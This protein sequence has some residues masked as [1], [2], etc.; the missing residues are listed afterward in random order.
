M[1]KSLG[2][3]M[4]VL[5]LG[6]AACPV[7][8][9]EGQGDAAS[10]RVRKVDLASAADS[11]RVRS[12]QSSDADYSSR[13]RKADSVNAAQEDAR[14]RVAQADPTD[15]VQEG[16]R[17]RSAQ[18]A[19]GESV[20]SNEGN[21]ATAAGGEENT[22]TAGTETPLLSAPAAPEKIKT[23]KYPNSKLPVSTS[24]PIGSVYYDYVDKLEGMGY[25]KSM[26]I[27]TRPYSRMDM[28]RWTLEARDALDKNPNATDFVFTMVLRLEKALAPEIA[29]IEAFNNDEKPKTRFKVQ[30]TRVELAGTDLHSKNGYEYRNLKNTRWQ[31]FSQNNKGHRYQDGFNANASIYMDGNLGRDLALSVTARA[32]WDKENHLTG[33]FDEAYLA[34][35]LGIWNI[36]IGKQAITWGQGVTGNLLF[37]D[38]ARP[39]TMFK[40]SN[41][42]QP[43]SKG[44]LA[45]L[46]QTKFTA[47]ASRLDGHRTEGGVK[48]HDHPWLLGFRADL[49]WK[50]FTLGLARGSMLGG[51]G[52][53][54]RWGDFGKWLIGHNAYHD[55][56][57]NDIAGLDFRWRM[58][59]LQIYGEM[60]G[61]DQAHAFPSE[62]AYRA[63]IYVPRLSYDGTWDMRLEAAH[64]GNPWYG[65]STYRAGWTYH[66]DIMGDYMGA[67][68][69]RYYGNINY[70]ASARDKIG[71][72]GSYWKLKQADN[73]SHKVKNAWLTYD[74]I[75]GERDSLNFMLGLSDITRGGKY[76]I[77][78]KDKIIR[79]IWEHQY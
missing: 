70:Y 11:S 40:I 53:G 77:S 37:S 17:V 51:E 12:V 6:A 29:Q 45:F 49:V 66:N 10:S 69:D 59:G 62:R 1:N 64:T 63:G 20:A 8:S 50:N 2:V 48:D 46:G 31:S 14:V 43:K 22:V 24:M 28:A 57:W 75:I 25:I 65:H 39:R 18:A 44:F 72:H 13:V 74:K 3:L 36:D 58:P 55:D 21:I 16:A 52:N 78:A 68:A 30:S 38:N 60:Y 47:F 42:L 15:A 34:T 27:G 5:L 4:T 7:V 9:A 33:S 41:E 26:L 23:V 35:R 79:V 76:G 54:F 67:S 61:E 71:L 73:S 56:K 32:A 19:S